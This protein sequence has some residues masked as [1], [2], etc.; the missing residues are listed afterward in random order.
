MVI[1]WVELLRIRSLMGC[2]LSQSVPDA[3]AENSYSL[4]LWCDQCPLLQLYWSVFPS[5]TSSLFNLSEHR[6]P[7]GPSYMV[8]EDPV[9]ESMLA[10]RAPYCNYICTPL[11]LWW[12]KDCGLL[13]LLRAGVCILFIFKSSET[14]T[15]LVS[16]LAL[17]E[18]IRINGY[19]YF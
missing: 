4:W 15:I 17:S 7:W 1:P 2:R 19:D 9:S 11:S 5:L 3:Q 8:P 6:L 14:S 13:T 10:L 18:S 16:R 12:G